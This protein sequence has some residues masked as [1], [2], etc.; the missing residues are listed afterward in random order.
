MKAYDGNDPKLPLILMD[1]AFGGRVVDAVQ[2]HVNY[3]NALYGAGYDPHSILESYADLYL[4]D[5]YVGQVNNGGHS[6][7]I[8]NSGARLKSELPRALRAARMIG[9]DGLAA[10]LERCA[11]WIDGNP[12]EAVKQNG[13][14]E[15]AEALEE[16]DKAFFALQLSDNE[17][18]AFLNQQ[19]QEVRDRL[20]PHVFVPDAAQ[21]WKEAFVSR[22]ADRP[23]DETVQD[24]MDDAIAAFGPLKE[25][26]E[27]SQGAWSAE[28]SIERLAMGLDRLGEDLREEMGKRFDMLL[29]LY[30]G[31]RSAYY[32]DAW[33]W[34]FQHPN[35][36]IASSE[37]WTAQIEEVA[38][39]SPFAATDLQA[40]Q[41]LEVYKAL[42]SD[43]ALHR[44]YALGQ[45]IGTEARS[46]LYLNGKMPMQDWPDGRSALIRG[47]SAHFALQEDDTAATLYRLAMRRGIF[48]YPSL[49]MLLDRWGLPGEALAGAIFRDKRSWKLGQIAGRSKKDQGLRAL[50]IACYLPEAAQLGW[51]G[52]ELAEHNPANPAFA[53]AKKD[54]FEQG[55][56]TLMDRA[57]PEIHWFVE[58]PAGP[59]LFKATPE[60][61]AVVKGGAEV[62]YPRGVLEQ[63]R[64]EM[65][66]FLDARAID[67]P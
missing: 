44:S 14:S 66:E 37:D 29:N 20:T 22:I 16:C 12:N 63:A 50:A 57:R 65:H 56:I 54:Y 5:F 27:V 18:R 43:D 34:L 23:A 13:F 31:S 36:V 1:W 61:V 49:K 30:S 48:S 8:G 47:Q 59:V 41:L 6:Q 35:L 26:L 55:R 46:G 58:T 53:R 17:M 52:E 4:L 15:R 3:V 7:Y 2:A 60:S 24:A 19:T 25:W 32:L 64:W 11:G 28:R 40:R 67:R 62:T 33:V 45:A 38:R 42:P 21:T 51:S 9:S 10:V 39:Q